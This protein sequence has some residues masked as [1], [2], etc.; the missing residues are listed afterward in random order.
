MQ[1]RKNIIL[2]IFLVIDLSV[3]VYISVFSTLADDMS[4]VYM[5]E[6]SIDNYEEIDNLPTDCSID[7]ELF[8]AAKLD[9]LQDEIIDSDSGLDNGDN[10]F[11]SLTS[12]S[13]NIILEAN[14]LQNDDLH[15]DNLIDEKL[16][17]E[18]LI[19]TDDVNSNLIVAN[20]IVSDN[21]IFEKDV[22]ENKIDNGIDRN[23]SEITISE[24]LLTDNNVVSNNTVVSNNNVDADYNN[25]IENGSVSTDSISDNSVILNNGTDNIVVTNTDS[26]GN[27]G[28]NVSVDSG[29]STN[30]FTSVNPDGTE[31][32]HIMEVKDGVTYV[33]GIMIVNKTYPLPSTYN[34]GGILPEVT[35]AFANMQAQAAQQGLRIY[36]SSG[37]RNYNRQVRLYDYYIKRDGKAA[38]DTF[39]A[40]P[41]YSEHQ[42]GLTVDLNSINDSFSRT[43]EAKWVAEHA[44]EYGFIVRFPQGKEAITGYKYESWHLRYLGVENATKVYNSGL[45]LEE[46]LGVQSVYLD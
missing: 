17:D 4:N 1:I 26:N 10:D 41:G 30:M 12:L 9:N 15:D 25:I 14:T 21:V 34:P 24:N 22:S 3:F 37:F 8:D 44:H 43:P 42:T 45:C 11:E 46:F 7:D 35:N 16:S 6:T 18:E 20:D 32:A 29:N 5:D 39:S 19:E 36:I 27:I 13:E 28:D 31:V 2:I 23:D 33:D 38:A 40:R